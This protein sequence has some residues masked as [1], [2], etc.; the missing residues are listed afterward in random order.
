MAWNLQVVGHHGQVKLPSL[1]TPSSLMATDRVAFAPF[2][3]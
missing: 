1:L 3:Y 2:A